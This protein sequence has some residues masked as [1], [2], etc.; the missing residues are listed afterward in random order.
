MSLDQGRA[1]LQTL[2]ASIASTQAASVRNQ[3]ESSATAQHL[4]QLRGEL[5]A[6]QHRL[7]AANA[8]VAARQK[9]LGDLGVVLDDRIRERDDA[10]VTG[11]EKERQ[12]H[13]AE[14][15]LCSLQSRAEIL[16][17]RVTEQVCTECMCKHLINLMFMPRRIYC[18]VGN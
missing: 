4:E 1:E 9:E 10:L 11:A 8:A 7:K 3:N 16:E 2:R 15:K 13:A 14:A 18:V 12:C 17:K 5:E 6:A